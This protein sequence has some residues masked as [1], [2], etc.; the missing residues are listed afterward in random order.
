MRE[1]IPS[2][3]WLRSTLLGVLIIEGFSPLGASGQIHPGVAHRSYALPNRV[4]IANLFKAI[5]R[6]DR[7]E[8]FNLN[9]LSSGTRI[10][11][12]ESHN[13]LAALKAAIKHVVP[14]ELCACAPITVIKFFRQGKGIGD[15]EIMLGDVISFSSWTGDA[16][17]AKTQA[18]FDWLDARGITR[19]RKEFEA[20]HGP[21]QVSP[22]PFITP[23]R[24]V[25][26]GKVNNRD[27]FGLL[28]RAAD[29]TTAVRF[30]FPG[31]GEWFHSPL[32]LRVVDEGDVRLNT[33]SLVLRVGRSAYITRPEMQ[34]LLKGLSQLNLE[35][36]ESN[37]TEPFGDVFL[38]PHVYAMRI[39][40]LS[41][42]G[43]AST[44]FPPLNICEMLAPLDHNLTSPR[45]LWEF[46]SLLVDDGCGIPG[47]LPDAYPDHLLGR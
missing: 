25:P 1:T 14:S 16:R 24:V 41:S 46:R 34:N 13:D 45:A 18:W 47:F 15:V 36:S 33:A 35:W 22:S 40:V 4:D 19:P 42:V 32:I 44:Q 3:W 29:G 31:E 21:E 9:G 7:I 2:Y 43:T 8:V 27:E 10:Y 12:S 17:I 30:F 23:V 39:T 26:Q 11:L 20:E 38:L 5:D 6:S 28:Q 37:G